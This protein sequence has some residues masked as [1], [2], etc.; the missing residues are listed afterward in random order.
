M[1][2]IFCLASLSG[3]PHYNLTFLTGRSPRADATASD[4]GGTGPFE[5]V[6]LRRAGLHIPAA[7]HGGVRHVSAAGHRV[8]GPRGRRE[9]LEPAGDGGG[10]RRG[11][12]V[13]PN[14]ATILGRGGA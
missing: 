11:A 14:P 1:S 5:L 3:F 4:R 7:A 12:G 9:Q 6:A 10:A 2:R 13:R 8:L